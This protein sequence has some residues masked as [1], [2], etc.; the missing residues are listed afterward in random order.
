MALSLR[1]QHPDVVKVTR[2][3]DRWQHQVD[4]RPFKH[5]RLIRKPGLV[6]PEGN[7]EYGMKLVKRETV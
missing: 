7:N 4:Y 2:K 5:N 1:Q 3:Y 6:I